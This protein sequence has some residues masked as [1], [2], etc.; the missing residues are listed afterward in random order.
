MGLALALVPG[1]G[2]WG[3]GASLGSQSPRV[4]AQN[5][6]PVVAS[7]SPDPS[8]SP[9]PSAS[10]DPSA[11]PNPSS[12]SPIPEPNPSPSPDSSSPNP[13]P[14]PDSSSLNSSP[15]PSS[16]NPS[17]SPDS[18]L[19]PDSSSPGSSSPDA[20][21]SPSPSPSPQTQVAP[22]DL[23]IADSDRLFAPHLPTILQSLPMGTQLR[24]PPQILLGNVP[25]LDAEGL[26]VQV[27]AARSP[28]ITTINLLTCDRGLFPCFVG[29][30]I[31]EPRTSPNAQR[32]LERHRTAA[33]PITLVPA[34]LNTPLIQGFLL[35]GNLQRPPYGFSSVMWE[36]GKTIY[37]LSFPTEERQN[38]LYMALYMARS[39]PIAA[40]MV[41]TPAP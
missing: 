13:S 10:P 24:L 38:L 36:Q 4:L 2:L 41:G 25:T 27:M 3:M 34:G 20:S 40:P 30:I 6:D 33:T 17:P 16:P 1:L 14:S 12:L 39:Q 28:A 31:I 9:N 23:G 21:P 22:P 18:S 29:S 19:N 15:N 5:P 32:E 11:S 35:D 8:A 37:T 7:P 26:R